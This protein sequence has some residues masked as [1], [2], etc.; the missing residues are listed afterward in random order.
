MKKRKE[1]Q[2]SHEKFTEEPGSEHERERRRQGDQLAEN[3]TSQYEDERDQ[4]A[5][6]G[7]GKGLNEEQ[8]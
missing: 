6:R 5:M 2:C 8:S 7:A 3:E 4:Q 1:R